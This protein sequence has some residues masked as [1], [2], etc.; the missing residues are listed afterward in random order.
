MVRTRYNRG[1]NAKAI[2]KQINA[3]TT[4]KNLGV[5]YSHRTVAAIMANLTMGN[6]DN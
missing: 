3:T 4:A 1:L 6:Y 2:A 5:E